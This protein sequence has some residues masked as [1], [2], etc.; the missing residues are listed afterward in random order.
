MPLFDE[1]PDRMPT[2]LTAPASEEHWHLRERRHRLTADRARLQ[3]SPAEDGYSRSVYSA[4]IRA[5]GRELLNARR[6]RVTFERPVSAS[7]Q[8]IALTAVSMSEATAC[9]CD[10]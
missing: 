5:H 9:G 7:R 3:V 8:V 4:A 2:R 10:T 6:Q 1:I